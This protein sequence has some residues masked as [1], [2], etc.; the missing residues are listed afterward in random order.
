MER[1][2]GLAP[3]ATDAAEEIAHPF[4]QVFGH[5]LDN[6]IKYRKDGVP[7]K[8]HVSGVRNLKAGVWEIRIKDNGIGIPA[9][10]LTKIFDVFQRL[11]PRSLYPGTGIGL[12]ICK[13]IIE[14][15]GGEL[16]AES[17]PGEGSTFT[18]TVPLSRER[19]A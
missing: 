14:V 6:S 7:P 18:F 10:F 19:Q 15:H 5:L 11:H 2:G 12:A 13:K 4:A 3:G 8:I 1:S 9:E 17:D 16:K